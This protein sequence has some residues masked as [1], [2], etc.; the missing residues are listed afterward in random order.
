MGKD[1]DDFIFKWS[2]LQ[3]IHKSDEL[4][5]LE[6]D[7]VFSEEA[8]CSSVEVE[9]FL[10]IEQLL[11]LV[12]DLVWHADSAGAAIFATPWLINRM[13]FQLEFVD[14]ALLFEWDR[15]FFVLKLFE[16]VILEGV[17]KNWEILIQQHFDKI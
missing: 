8:E 10:V 11:S 14:T 16:H 12:R 13:L 3:C 4:L 7:A 15:I 17:P 6:V 9:K 1:G 2:I 5:K